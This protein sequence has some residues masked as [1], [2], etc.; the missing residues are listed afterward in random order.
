MKLQVSCLECPLPRLGLIFVF[1]AEDNEIELKEGEYVINI[2]MVDEDWWMG[3][4]ARGQTGLFPSN[5]VELVADDDAPPAISTTL[6]S[7]P[8][9]PAAGPPGGSKAG[10]T[11]TAMYDYEA[12]GEHSQ[13]P[14]RRSCADFPQRTTNSASQRQ[15][16]LQIW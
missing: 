3:G 15:P 7:T 13:I 9:A 11:A 12:T 5:Y 16:R 2:D 8:S 4:N 6:N 14:E 1:I 10:P